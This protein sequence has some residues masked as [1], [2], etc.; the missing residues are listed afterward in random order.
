MEGAGTL[1]VNGAYNNGIH[2][3]KDLTIQNL[4]LTSS[5]YN[6]ALKGNDSVTVTGGT[7]TSNGLG[8]PAIY[9]TADITVSNASL[10]SN[11]SEGVC[12]DGLNSIALNDCDLTANNTKRNSNAAFLDT[13]MIC[14][15]NY[16][17][18]RRVHVYRICERKDHEREGRNRLHRGGHRERD[19]GFHQHLD[20]HR[21]RLR[22]EL[23]R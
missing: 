11:L 5:A 4:S 21:R 14:Q 3:T 17:P 23:Y 6:N 15:S 9:F 19:A 18:Y 10:I 7:Y 22:D 20:A 16:E 2:T 13:I 1:V 8:S 12:I